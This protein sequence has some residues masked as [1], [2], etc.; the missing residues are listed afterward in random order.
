[1]KE[2]IFS[3][4]NGGT[5]SK[6]FACAVRDIKTGKEN[7]LPFSPQLAPAAAPGNPLHQ[8]SKKSDRKPWRKTCSFVLHP[9]TGPK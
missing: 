4:I 2:D 7:G 3:I 1:M 8:Q 5:F 9:L 6:P